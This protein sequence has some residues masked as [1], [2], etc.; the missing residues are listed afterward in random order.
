MVL[1]SYWS[2]VFC[3]H[4]CPASI[5]KQDI[6]RDHE[7]VAL[8]ALRLLSLQVFEPTNPFCMAWTCLWWI[9]GIIHSHLVPHTTATAKAIPMYTTRWWGCVKSSRTPFRVS[10]WLTSVARTPLAFAFF[11]R[12]LPYLALPSTRHRSLSAIEADSPSSLDSISR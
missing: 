10:D 5:S 11:S 6:E 9:K 2:L 8:V 7:V 3:Y 1:R 12:L 4:C